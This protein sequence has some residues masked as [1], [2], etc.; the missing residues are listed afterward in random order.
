MNPGSRSAPRVG[1]GRENNPGRVVECTN[2]APLQRHLIHHHA[3]FPRCVV[4]ARRGRQPTGIWMS[5][6]VV[7]KA[8]SSRMH[9]ALR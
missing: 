9:K 4:R 6:W 7:G 1:I 5:S 2:V 8:E 3:M